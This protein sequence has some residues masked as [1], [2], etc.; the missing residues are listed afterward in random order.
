[1]AETYQEILDEIPTWSEM[2]GAA[3]YVMYHE[4]LDAG[5]GPGAS[6]TAMVTDIA[7]RV[8]AATLAEILG[9]KE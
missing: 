9:E 3:E 4:I 7:K 2:G 5:V 6:R 1:M 8:R